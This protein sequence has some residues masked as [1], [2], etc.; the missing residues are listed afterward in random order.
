MPLSKSEAR[1]LATRSLFLQTLW[2]YRTMQGGGYLFTLWPWLR[3]TDASPARV[4]ASA[5]YLNAHPVLAAFAI[6]ALRRRLE[7]GH[8]ERDPEAFAAWQNTLCGPLGVMGDALIWDRY[9]PFL[10]SLGVLVLLLFRHVEVWYVLAPALLLLYNIPLFL[11]RTWG[12]REGYALGEHVLDVLSRPVFGLLRRRLTQAGL[13]LAGLLFA[14]GI[15]ASTGESAMHPV[16][17][18]WSFLLMLI[19]IRRQWPL[20][21]SLFAVV[22]SALALP[23]LVDVFF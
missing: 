22:I 12:V 19:G 6:G 7:E 15:V 5:D 13:V 23:V 18:C 14:A 20:L 1:Q 17:F 2:N 4:R 3:R 11:L 8:V 16:Q 10:F 9:K 21:I